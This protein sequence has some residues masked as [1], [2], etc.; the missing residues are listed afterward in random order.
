MAEILITSINPGSGPVGTTIELKGKMVTS[1]GRYH[2]HW[3]TT[4][5]EPLKT[6]KAT[7]HEVQD[8]FVLPAAVRGVYWVILEDTS[9]N[10]ISGI[11]VT[12]TPKIAIEPAAGWVGTRLKVTGTNFPEGAVSIRYDGKG[13]ATATPDKEGDFQI[14][15]EA[16][17]SIV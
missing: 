1:G 10:A 12:V 2:I 11:L 15:F 8:T 9:A 3:N 7:N 5:T 14:E 17:P 6:G 16:P 13:V 4:N